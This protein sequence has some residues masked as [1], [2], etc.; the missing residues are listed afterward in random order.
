MKVDDPQLL[1]VIVDFGEKRK[2]KCGW[3]NFLI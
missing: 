1:I 3:F 2:K